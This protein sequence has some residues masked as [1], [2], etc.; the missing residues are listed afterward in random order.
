MYF[1]VYL[2]RLWKIWNLNTESVSC[3]YGTSSICFFDFSSK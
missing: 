3:C 2:A 1:T